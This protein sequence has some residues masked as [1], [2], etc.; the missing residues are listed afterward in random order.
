MTGSPRADVPV[1]DGG[2][3]PRW[4]GPVSLAARLG[5]RARRAR[6]LHTHG[7]VLTGRWEPAPDVQDPWPRTGSDV[8]VR[9]SRGVSV[10]SRGP[11]LLGLAF[12]RVAADGFDVLMSSCAGAGPLLRVPPAPARSWGSATYSTLAPYQVG[13]RWTWLL[14]S[15]SGTATAGASTDHDRTRGEATVS[16]SAVSRDG[17]HDVATLTVTPDPTVEVESFDPVT[18]H[19]TDA[20]LAPRW[21]GAV[22]EAAYSGSRRGSG[23]VDQGA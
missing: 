5:G 19:P 20:V 13:P 16:L 9:L 2:A 7:L 8:V 23:R 4:V 6:A 22:R 17:R 18:H 12:R 3:L 14:A 10:T 1:A 11:D 15:A 21:L